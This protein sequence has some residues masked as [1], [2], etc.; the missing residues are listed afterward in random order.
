MQLKS[1]GAKY[2]NGRIIGY[3]IKE[4]GSEDMPTL[5]KLEN[6]KNAL[7][8]KK[9]EFSNLELKKT[10]DI[11]E[12]TPQSDKVSLLYPEVVQFFIDKATRGLSKSYYYFSVRDMSNNHDMDSAYHLGVFKHDKLDRIIVRAIG[13]LSYTPLSAKLALLGVPY[14]EIYNTLMY[15]IDSTMY[16]VS[17]APVKFMNDKP[18]KLKDGE[19]RNN[20]YKREVNLKGN[21]FENS[22]G[23]K[24]II[25]ED[26]DF[27]ELK[28][29][30]DMFASNPRI[31]HIFLGGVRR[32]SKNMIST[33]SMFR[34]C[35]EIESIDTTSLDLSQ[36]KIVKEMFCSCRHLLSLSLNTKEL[37]KLENVGGMFDG[38]QSILRLDLTGMN[39]HNS[40]NFSNMFRCCEK[41]VSLIVPFDTA[42]M[43]KCDSMFH[44]C[45]RLRTLDLTT[46]SPMFCVKSK[47]HMFSGCKKLIDL[48]YNRNDTVM[49]QLFDEM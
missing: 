35:L 37:S 32:T 16:I 33:E 34:Y 41:L 5:I 31:E 2:E 39:T 42:N 30:N 23:V 49:K 19:S 44:G 8:F 45:R 27:S 21:F 43:D 10:G 18:A 40:I 46:F 13:D 12:T 25:I 15:V 14:V 29:A 20:Y 22:I 1:V 36:V 48:N 4:D 7:R 26:A 11:V 28:A 24:E 38:C 3:Y 17:P 47:N 6:V 9:A